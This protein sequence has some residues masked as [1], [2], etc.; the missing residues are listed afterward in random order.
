MTDASSP[1][2][3]SSI[4]EIFS[5][6]SI[7]PSS[8]LNSTLPDRRKPLAQLHTDS[9]A[10]L[11]TLDHATQELIAKL[12][13]IGSEMLASST[14]LKYEV[15]LLAGDIT[16]MEQKFT[17][18]LK[19]QVADVV[20]TKTAAMIRV[21]KLEVVRKRLLQVLDIFAQATELRDDVKANLT[22]KPGSSTSKLEQQVM[23]L[24]SE[25]KFKLASGKVESLEQLI[26]VWK[27]THEYASMQEFVSK[28]KKLVQEA[29]TTSS[30]ATVATDESDRNGTSTPASVGSRSP[31]VTSGQFERAEINVRA[32][33]DFL[34]HEA[35][36]GYLGFIESLKKI[37]QA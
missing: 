28:L 21:E 25:G 26:Q 10:L 17:D 9:V 37:R 18:Q 27:S 33:A 22:A 13:K 36:E 1:V 4:L 31:A 20:S 24:L 29:I 15:E 6:P 16:T 35:R 19:P 23:Q 32:S 8:Y 7:T 5:N 30:K 2:T 14:R 3:T 34:R 12:E 11:S